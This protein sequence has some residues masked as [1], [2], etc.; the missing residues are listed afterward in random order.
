V[1][2]EILKAEGSPDIYIVVKDGIKILYKSNIRSNSAELG[3]FDVAIKQEINFLDPYANSFQ[4]EIGLILAIVTAE[5]VDISE[6]ASDRWATTSCN[7][8]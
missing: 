2:N 3:Q 1:S 8:H 4:K 7:V 5:V 6:F